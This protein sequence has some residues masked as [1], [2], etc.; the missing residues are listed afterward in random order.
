MGSIA[1]AIEVLEDV[2]RPLGAQV[3][4]PGHGPVCGP[5]VIDEVLGYLR[6]VQDVAAR[7]RERGLPALDAARQA[8]LGQYAGWL[9]SERI[10]GNLYR[11]YAELDGA[12]R[13]QPIDLI[14]AVGDMITYNGGRPLTCHA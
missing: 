8:D 3:I 7:G 1:G 4:G 6:F 13:G 9:D 2:L 11:G 12:E 14:A 10:V 5:E